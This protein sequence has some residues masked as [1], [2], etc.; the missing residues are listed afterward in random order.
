MLRLL[1]VAA[2]LGA[3][4]FPSD[5][6]GQLT[7]AVS[8]GWLADNQGVFELDVA[9]GVAACRRLPDG[10]AAD[11][12]CDVRVLTQLYTRYLRPRSAAAFGLLE[13]RDRA[14]LALAERLFAGLAPFSSDHF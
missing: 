8:D 6:A 7:L 11:L 13:A 10:A 9:G 12:A 4:R 2:A 1:D 14:V 5:C 3:Y